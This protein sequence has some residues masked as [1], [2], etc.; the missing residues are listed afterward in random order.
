MDKGHLLAAGCSFKDFS[1]C[2]VSFSRKN[3]HITSSIPP[4]T[5]LTNTMSTP[6][7]KD[8]KL[9]AIH[10]SIGCL[11]DLQ[12]SIKGE[13]IDNPSVLSTKFCALASSLEKLHRSGKNMDHSSLVEVPVELLEF[14]DGEVSNPELYQQKSLADHEYMASSLTRRIQ[15]LQGIKSG[16]ASAQDKESVEKRANI[17][18]AP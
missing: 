14:L 6:A 10:A 4:K 13:N 3:K 18:Q 11:N 17:K 2:L 8:P 16:V 7:S 5:P 15:Y 9:V 1:A 12:Q